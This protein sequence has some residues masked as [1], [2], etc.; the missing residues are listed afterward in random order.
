[1]HKRIIILL[2]AVLGLSVMRVQAQDPMFSQFYANPL[3]LNPAMAGTNVCPR[4]AFNFRDQWPS[5]PGTFMTYAASYDEHFDKIYGGIGVQFWGDRA[6]EGGILNTY[7]ASA[8][9]SFKVKV[10]KK[11]NMRF[12]LQAAFQ[13][14]SLDWSKLTFGDMIDPRY[15]FVY[16]TN[17]NIANYIN[18]I[19]T[20][21]FSF[22]FLGYTPHVYF[23]FAAK[24]I[25]TLSLSGKT[26]PYSFLSGNADGNFYDM[27]KL[28]AHVG[29]NFDLKRKSK[30]E[31]SF[32]DISISPNFIY[33]HQLGFNYFSEGLYM[34]FY[35]FTVGVWCRHGL[36]YKYD[37][38]MLD[39]SGN[40]IFGPDSITP[41]TQ[42]TNIY[43]SDAIIFMFGL[44]Y[45]M[46][47]VAYSY[48]LTISRLAS[49]TT[50]GSHEVSVQV[51][52]PC[53]KKRKAIKDLKCPSF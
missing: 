51:L 1:M 39:Q 46:F 50:G 29:A 10:S 36:T 14:K 21:D 6:G 11:F 30:K 38:P 20:L 22:G 48:D 26:T 45:N 35:P 42:K 52:L 17:E 7:N 18:H 33:E 5:M 8:M 27:L 12:A 47:K 44:E 3:F 41:M 37:E 34:K 31:T 40:V 43:N 2:V 16:S 53:P 28:T 32:G 13:N 4:L 25:A 23:G 9:Y 49:A 19:N 15:G 24:H